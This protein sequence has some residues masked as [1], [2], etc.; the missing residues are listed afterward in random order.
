[1]RKVS[2]CWLGTLLLQGQP[3]DESVRNICNDIRFR[4]CSR[5]GFSVQ[6]AYCVKRYDGHYPVY[7]PDGYVLHWRVAETPEEMKKVPGDVYHIHIAFY[8]DCPVSESF[9]KA[10]Y[11]PDVEL[12]PIRRA[13]LDHYMKDPGGY[14]CYMHERVIF[15]C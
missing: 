12:T 2:K 8:S 5:F 15:N 4:W 13:E 1:M 9:I 14:A 6:F 10:L 11:S 3:S 7:G